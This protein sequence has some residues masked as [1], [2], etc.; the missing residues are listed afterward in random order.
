M[1]PRP[2]EV[3]GPATQERATR[4]G[5]VRVGRGGRPPG[6]EADGGDADVD[7][8]DGRARQ[9]VRVEPAMLGVERGQQL[10][11]ARAR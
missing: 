11:E 4:I 1:K 3:D 8:L 7:Q 10:L 2:A 6:Q 9:I 5:A